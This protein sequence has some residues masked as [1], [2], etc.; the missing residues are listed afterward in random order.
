VKIEVQIYGFSLK[1]NK[2]YF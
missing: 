1:T 2:I